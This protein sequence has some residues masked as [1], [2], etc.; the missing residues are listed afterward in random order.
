MD[1]NDSSYDLRKL[2]HCSMELMPFKVDLSN[3]DQLTCK[4]VVQ[5]SHDIT[6]ITSVDPFINNGV[7]FNGKLILSMNCNLVKN[8]ENCVLLVLILASVI[9]WL[10][11]TW[12][13]N[14][15]LLQMMHSFIQT[16]CECC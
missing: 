11:N 2:M 5:L 12:Y 13:V 16:W 7:S 15:S 8:G 9:Q 10:I 3:F 1:N 4:T 14:S 6:G